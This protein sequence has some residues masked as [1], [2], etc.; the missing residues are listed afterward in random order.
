MPSLSKLDNCRT[1]KSVRGLLALF[2]A[3]A[4]AAPTL[5]AQDGITLASAEAASQKI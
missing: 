2:L 5:F 4:V 3:L 1:G